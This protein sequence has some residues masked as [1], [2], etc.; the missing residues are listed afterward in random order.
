[1]EFIMLNLSVKAQR[2]IHDNE[3]RLTQVKHSEG[4]MFV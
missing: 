1:M 4:K 3:G 2:K